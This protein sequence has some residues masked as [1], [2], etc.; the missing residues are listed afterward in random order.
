MVAT[1]PNGC[2]SFGCYGLFFA[3]FTAVVSLVV[4]ASLAT[5]GPFAII[6]QMTT[7]ELEHAAVG[8]FLLLLL[9][10]LL[11]GHLLLLNDDDC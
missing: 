4:D 9:L 1:H 11:L 7:V 3:S 5:I 6:E 2:C 10:L 8:S